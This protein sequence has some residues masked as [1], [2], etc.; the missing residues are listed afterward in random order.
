MNYIAHDS[1]S[2]KPDESN[3]TTLPPS[4][5]KSV[6]EAITKPVEP[7]KAMAKSAIEAGYS[8]I[9]RRWK[10][11]AGRPARDAKRPL[12]DDWQQFSERQMSP[13]ELAKV[14]REAPLAHIS[15]ACGYAGVICIDLDSEKP[16]LVAAYRSAIPESPVARRGS[17]GRADFYRV[18]G[19]L[20]A[21]R[22]FYGRDNK[23]VLEILATGSNVVIPPSTHPETL[24]P[25]VWL[26]D[27]S[28]FDTIPDELPTVT[29]EQLSQ[30]EEVLKPWLRQPKVKP[31]ERVTVADADNISEDHRKRYQAMADKALEKQISKLVT[32]RKGGRNDALYRSVCA[33]AVFVRHGFLSQETV[34]D[35]A[36][37]AASANGLLKENGEKDVRKTIAEALKHQ[38]ELP[39]LTERKISRRKSSPSEN[40][41]QT[42]EDASG[43][44][45]GSEPVEEVSDTENPC[46]YDGAPEF[47]EEGLALSFAHKH[48]GDLRHVAAFNRWLHWNGSVWQEEETHLAFDLAR[49]HCRDEAKRAT[50]DKDIASLSDA[51]TRSNVLTLAKADRRIAATKDQWNN[52]DWLL[53]TP[54]GIIDLR[55]ARNIGF[56]S[57]KYITRMTTVAPNAQGCPKWLNFLDK[58]TKGNQELIAYLKRMCG[59][60]LTGS[61]REHS[62]TF[63]YGPGGNGK[64]TFLA[65]LTGIMGEMHKAADVETF[66]ERKQAAH[67][68]ELARLHNA[69]LVTSQE[70]EKGQYWAEARLKKLTGGDPITARFMRCDD[71][72]FMPKFKLILVG[73]HKP[74]FRSV[75][76]AIR[77]RL[78]LIPFDYQV[79]KAEK[80]QNLGEELK[81]EWG[82]ILAWMIEGCME[83]QERGLAAPECVLKA[84]N[85]YLDSEDL[86]G[87]WIANRCN[88][89]SF[90][91]TNLKHLFDS[92]RHFCELTGIKAVGNSR[93]LAAELEKRLG[94]GSKKVVSGVARFTGINLKTPEELRSSG[95][96]TV[97]EPF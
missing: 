10:P 81:A 45:T 20:P 66:A 53:G 91:K 35:A 15:L 86:I 92:W 26:G 50:D 59:Y 6:I 28:I 13:S 9:P 46:D 18:V 29:V 65:A 11:A 64:G 85:D 24:Q 38:D 63:I 60:S 42:R 51:K 73:N 37:A 49:H 72:E 80:N 8:P 61:I 75:D 94:E 62:L 19:E 36:Y 40:G 32:M 77:R 89:T 21:N 54:G 76:E 23:P 88:L 79:P 58:V 12:L 70:T 25:Y 74:K 5:A 82:G 41:Y 56:D 27:S 84:T 97:D 14:F 68:T 39:K 93:D 83:W 57:S 43:K 69:R 7:F 90:G 52:D 44:F 1:N 47:S 71:F 30:L 67:T 78:H 16:D 3:L 87:L 4:Y 33:L 48:K 31:S 2:V 22:K 17:K 95:A 96:E 55:T 34:E